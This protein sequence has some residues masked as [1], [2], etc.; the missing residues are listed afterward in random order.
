[1]Y[2][3]HFQSHI[4]NATLAGGVAIGATA[5]LMLHPYGALLIGSIAGML[6]VLGFQHVSVRTCCNKFV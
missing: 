1:M 2:S 3:I 6:S 5:D 4:Q